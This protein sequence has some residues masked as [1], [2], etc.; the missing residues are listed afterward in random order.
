MTSPDPLTAMLFCSPLPP[1]RVPRDAPLTIGRQSD[2][3]F[4]LRRGDVSRRHAEVSFSEGAHW[5]RDLGSTN[6]T[7]VNGER[8]TAP[9]ALEPGDR[10]AIGSSTLTFCRLDPAAGDGANP[11]GEARTLVA[12]PPGPREAFQ[13]DLAEI[14]AFALLQMLELGSKTGVLEVS[15][16]AGVGRVW[17]ASGGPVHAETEK[18]EGFEAAIE[19]VNTE[20]GTFRFEPRA[21]DREVSLRA[22]VTDLLLEASRRADEEAAAQP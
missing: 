21:L 1:Q 14:P 22:S 4:A 10:I 13:G 2:C 17:F 6:G 15:G 11:P 12:A 20:R 16:P 9:H 19:V 8:L 5:L 18:D 3:G 7:F